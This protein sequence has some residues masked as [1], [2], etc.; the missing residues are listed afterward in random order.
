MFSAKQI[1]MIKEQAYCKVPTPFVCE[2]FICN[3]YPYSIN[4]IVSMPSSRYDSRLALLLLTETDI[5][6][7]IKKRLEKLHRSSQQNLCHICC[8]VLRMMISFYQNLN[9]P[10]LLL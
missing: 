4:E 3:V 1:D 7:T 5:S 10:F 9:V 2:K 8:R 6:E